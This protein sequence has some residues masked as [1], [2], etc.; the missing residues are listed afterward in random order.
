MSSGT[1]PRRRR[2]VTVFRGRVD[3]MYLYTDR[4]EGAE[5]VP[6]PLRERFGELR[7]VMTLLLTDDRPLA[8]V[9][10]GEVLDAIE[11]QGFFLQLPPPP[12]R[13]SWA[14]DPPGS[15]REAERSDGQGT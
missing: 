7:E 11:A 12:E 15:R 2:L 4:S 9:R 6:G 10:A 3:E 8:R 1:S 13:P 5:R 14:I